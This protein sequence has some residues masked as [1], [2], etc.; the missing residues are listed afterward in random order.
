MSN[1]L[2]EDPQFLL[3]F[4][5][6][7][8]SQGNYFQM[9]QEIDRLKEENNSIRNQFN[10]ATSMGDQLEKVHQK[11]IQLSDSSTKIFLL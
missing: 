6:D 7:I 9:Q 11:N 3:Q 5:S 2:S 10:E 8:D 1:Y 4:D